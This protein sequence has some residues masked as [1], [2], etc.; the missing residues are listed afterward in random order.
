MFDFVRSHSRLMLGLLM[1]LIIPS[2]VFF[3]VEGYARFMEEGGRAVARIDGRDITRT[4]W[5]AAHERAVR[6]MREQM[7]GVDLALIDNPEMKRRTLDALVRDRVLLTAAERMALAPG[8]ERLQRLFV[9]DPQFAGL[10]NPDGSVNRD[11]LTAQGM[12]SETFALQLRQELGMRQVLSGVTETAFAP[13]AAASASLGA[14]LQRREAQVQIFPMAEYRSRANPTDADLEAY[15]QANESRFQAPEQARIEYVVLDLG[16]LTRGITVNEKELR[17]YYEQNAS[18][19]ATAEERQASHILVTADASAPAADRAKARERAE[20]LL[21]EVRRNPA[22]FAEV[23]RRDSQDP[24]SAAQGG[25]LGFNARGLMVKPFDDA[26]F[27]MKAGEISNVV[28][29]EYGFHIIRLT[30]VRGGDR[31][32]F[33]AVRAELEQEVRRSLA[34][35]Q[36]AEAAEKFTNKVYEQPDS[37]QPVIDELKLEKRTATVQRTAEAGAAGVLASRK[38][39]EAVFSGDVLRE[40]RNTQAIETGSNQLTSARLVEHQP[41]R[42]RPL[43]EVRDEVRARVVEAQAMAQAR[44]AGEAR[45]EEVKKA[46]DTV[47]PETL[48]VSRMGSQGLPRPLLDAVLQASPATLPLVRGVEIAE[49]GYVVVKVN[50]VLPRQALPG[51]DLALIGQYAQAWGGAEAQ[52]TINAL[53][54]RYKVKIEEERVRTALQTTS[55]TP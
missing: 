22:S 7:P 2:F 21:A 36:Y 5:D 17:D 38:L 28:E 35:R 24:G 49:L 11:L 10:R 16:A 41:A 12:S 8:D 14:L 26:L 9:S 43:T 33:E 20:A 32:P 40:K 50:Q 46:P 42:L 51:G 31:K 52:A 39:L 23:A 1:V 6:R 25:D 13:A 53:K 47:L 18:R 45:V 54:A 44:K 48:I 30:A 3:G 55:T 15:Y 34:Q 27:G 19:F 37:L 4:E 29:T